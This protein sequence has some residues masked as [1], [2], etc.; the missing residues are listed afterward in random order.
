LWG[1]LG[2]KRISAKNNA[3]INSAAEQQLVGWPLPAADVDR[4]ESMRNW[5][6]MI[7]KAG[8][9]DA[10]SVFIAGNT[11][12]VLP[13]LAAQTGVSAKSASPYAATRSSS[14]AS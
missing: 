1:S 7:R 6:A 12:V 8:M 3:A 9:S 13:A 5:L 14:S 11:I 4:I 2:W 10:R